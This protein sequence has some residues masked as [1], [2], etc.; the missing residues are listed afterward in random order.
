MDTWECMLYTREVHK[1]VKKLVTELGS[2]YAGHSV[3]FG[4]FCASHL[5]S[6][7]L[8]HGK[9]LKEGSSEPILEVTCLQNGIFLPA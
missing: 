3:Y 2:R 8:E 6:E 5:G 7:K 9:N 1:F 4:M